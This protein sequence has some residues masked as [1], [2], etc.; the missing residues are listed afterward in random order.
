[1]LESFTFRAYVIAGRRSDTGVTRLNNFHRVH[2]SG[3][4]FVGL[5]AEL[6]KLIHDYGSNQRLQTSLPLGGFLSQSTS[7]HKIPPER[8]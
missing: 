3:L 8:I 2:K 4:T 1:M 6:K 5:V 7:R